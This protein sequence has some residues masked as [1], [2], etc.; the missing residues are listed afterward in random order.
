DLAHAVESEQA[1][2]L[3]ALGN[4]EIDLA[5]A[6]PLL[7]RQLEDRLHVGVAARQLVRAEALAQR[8]DEDGLR[9]RRAVADVVEERQVVAGAAAGAPLR[10]RL[11]QLQRALEQLLGA[12]EVAL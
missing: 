9:L 12:V 2:R 3:R 10:R 7:L 4:G 6:L 1:H 5:A 11:G 8:L